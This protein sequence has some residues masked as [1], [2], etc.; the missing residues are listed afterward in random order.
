MSTIVTRAGK[1]SPLTNAEV[2]AN[3]TNLNSDKLEAS[4]L[5]PYLLSA[6]A[7]ST[8]LPLAGGTLSGN[9]AFSGTGRRITGDFSSNS[10]ITDRILVQTSTNN[11]NTL[12]SILPSGT[13]TTS[14]YVAFNNS[15]PTNAGAIQ[16]SALSTDVRIQ[17]FANG[18]ATAIPLM[19][20]MQGTTVATVSTDSNFLIGTTTDNAT[21]KLQVAG[22]A[23][24]SANS[25]ST[26]LRITQEGT[27]NALLVEDSANPDST[28][29]VV[30]ANGNVISGYTAAI[31]TYG[32]NNQLQVLGTSNA[33]Q[34]NAAFRN[35]AFAPF[36]SLAHSRDAT[37]G[38]HTIV[39]SGDALGT[40]A[41]LG[42]DGT[43]FIQ[44]A[45]IS[46]S[47][48]GTPGTNDMPG[49]L[50]FSTT[51][52]GASSPT[53]RMR[54]D[55]LGNMSLSPG[56][57]I[58]N[59]RVR[60]A[61]NFTQGTTTGGNSFGFIESGT[62]QSD[63][64]NLFVTYRSEARTAAASFTLGNFWHFQASQ[65]TIGAGSTLT[66]QIGYLVESTLTGAT[67]NYGFYSDIASGTNRW[68]FF[69]NGTANNYFAG[70]T[71][72]GTTPD[73][74]F[75]VLL[76]GTLPS[77]SNNSGG[78]RA[79]ATIPS[80]TT[81]T[82]VYFD[83]VGTTQAA[84]FN[85]ASLIHFRALQST[86]GAGSTVTSQFGYLVDASLTGATN[87]YGFFSDIASG[88]GR[89][90][91]YANGTAKNI[92]AGQTSIGGL[93]DAESLRVTPVASA[94]NFLNL[95]GA[96]TTN[97]PWIQ[98][99]GS[100]SN[101]SLRYSTKGTGAHLFQTGGG[102][103][104]TQFYI[105]HTASAVNYVQAT[106]SATGNAV[107]ISAQGSDTNISIA[108][109]PKGT[110]G[111][112]IGTATPRTDLEL[113]QA[114]TAPVL[115]FE[116]GTTSIAT[117]DVYGGIEFYGND[118]SANASGVRARIQVTAADGLGGARLGFA[119]AA[120]TST[121]LTN[122]LSVT[123]VGCSLTGTTTISLANIT[124]GFA[125][126]NNRYNISGSF[127]Q[128][129][130][131]TA[132][133]IDLGSIWGNASSYTNFMVYMPR[134]DV[135]GNYWA[136]YAGTSATAKLFKS[137]AQGVHWTG[138]TWQLLG[139]VLCHT[140]YNSDATNF[141]AGAVNASKVLTVV[142]ATQVLLRMQNYTSPAAASG[143]DWVY[144]L[145]YFNYYR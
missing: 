87:N 50:V 42:S 88:T 73:T 2:D 117:N 134:I 77:S 136:N 62:V 35:D 109:T 36:L 54:I 131:D 46:S 26:A 138:T 60:L 98:A 57:T 129:N 5:S 91:F 144:S 142:T 61:G 64:T 78:Y 70:S 97:P 1:G 115:T 20:M 65:S 85:L 49:R 137:W 56:G 22:S 31:P 95:L 108:L 33:Y 124:S 100:D 21:D 89:W 63:V 119:A 32:F 38:S 125:D 105:T 8:Y 130:A 67:N 96:T 90:N 86:I 52:D 3:F 19:L 113:Y 18:T 81:S 83:S 9:L 127:V 133:D 28:P 120:G 99:N 123:N 118:S 16:L 104:V 23:V 93:E 27:G 71:G 135:V 79:F 4:A 94:V 107:A 30:D 114:S 6:T 53:E 141:P 143:T 69:A 41:F 12:W 74:T 102:T 59:Q 128:T 111:V 44:A 48:D 11:S 103:E 51:A 121:T 72:I 106:G 45:R 84:S 17:S 116:R 92:F 68:N 10:P 29:F 24:V 37:I 25:S 13:A 34:L 75:K 80:S 43:A 58:S 15:D 14:R 76:G 110:G 101:I 40:L 39:Q 145:E 126:L 7:A 112:G 55:N 122:R 140:A 139:A 82:T 66:T 47:V 132:T